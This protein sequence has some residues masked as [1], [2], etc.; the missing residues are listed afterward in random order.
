MI[1]VTTCFG[2]DRTE[3]ERKTSPPIIYHVCIH[4][5]V[6]FLTVIIIIIISSKLTV[7]LMKY[8]P[9]L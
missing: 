6:F 4:V 3:R 9:N 7:V 5:I 2:L 8:K 1:T